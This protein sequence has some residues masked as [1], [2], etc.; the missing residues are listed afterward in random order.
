MAERQPGELILGKY[1]IIRK[2]GQG[3]YGA[4]YLADSALGAVAIKELAPKNLKNP[5]DYP[6]FR[7][8]FEK[9]A[10]ITRAFENNPNVVI[11]YELGTEGSS[12]YL[13]LQYVDN[14]SLRGLLEAQ[15]GKLL[16][17]ELIYRVASQICN[18]LQAIH[19]HHLDVV[20]R[21][22][23]P[24]N[25][26]LTKQGQAKITDFGIAQIGHESLRTKSGN[27]HP[28]TPVYMSPEQAKTTDYL[29]PASDLYAL[30]LIIYEMATGQIFKKRQ[31]LPPSKLNPSITPALDAIIIKALQENPQARYNDAGLMLQHLERARQGRITPEEILRQV[32]PTQLLTPSISNTPAYPSNSRTSSPSPKEDRNVFRKTLGWLVAG[33]LFVV[34]VIAALIALNIGG[35]KVTPTPISG[36]TATLPATF[37]TT[38]VP[39]TTTAA[40]TII[41]TTAVATPTPIPNSTAT[42]L[43]SPTPTTVAPSPTIKTAAPTTAPIAPSASFKI[44]NTLTG[45]TDGVNSVAFSPDSKM[46][47]SGSKD[48]TIKLWDAATGKELRTLS[49]HSSSV[50]SVAFSPDGKTLA[51][52]SGYPENSIKL[53]DT[54]SGK[55]LRTLSG[56]S[57]SVYSI[58]FSPDGKSLASGS[59]DA[60]IKLWNV[61]SGK[62]LS[63]LTGHSSL[64]LSVAFSPDGK[65]LA[66]GSG[67]NSIKLWDVN[68]GQELNTLSGHS[69]YVSSVAFSPD[70]KTLASGSGDNSIKLWN[71]TSGNLI[72]TLKSHTGSVT[73]VAFS[74]DSKTLVSGSEDNSIKLW[75][76]TSGNLINTFKGHSNGVN[77]VAFSPDGKFLASGDGDKSI[78]LRDAAN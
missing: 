44:L 65:S 4:V 16:P 64:V 57:G 17:L 37:A 11:V 12:D 36:V 62:Q 60:S 48:A 9:E 38:I 54:T 21:D 61:A 3:G 8:R 29:T 42:S 10:R 49:G 25:I 69:F 7:E 53:W 66:S 73:S 63:T 71:A 26:L 45:H 41:A 40:A 28:G 18:G 19:N 20:H 59:G 6:I 23:K 58:A 52:G 47:A 34:I 76:V 33:G 39:T 27:P 15:Q 24:E 74:P 72:N 32:E 51:S 1:K 35:E 75:D 46:L 43:P 67:D 50:N 2:I 78:M 14:G 68:T 5:A 31:I 22:L 70:G 55:E 30:G 56:H 77:S 13:V